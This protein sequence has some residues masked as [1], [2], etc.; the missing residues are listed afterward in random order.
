LREEL[1]RVTSLKDA[2][3]ILEGYLEAALAPAAA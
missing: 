3:R 2:E 1:F